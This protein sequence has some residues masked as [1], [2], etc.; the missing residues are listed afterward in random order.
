M[1][2]TLSRLPLPSN[3]VTARIMTRRYVDALLLHGEHEV[4]MA[5]LLFITGFKQRPQLIE[6]LNSS[7]TTY[8]LGRKL[9][10]LVNSVTSFSNMP[11]ILIF[12]VG[13]LIV[14]VS[15]AYSAFLIFNY[16]VF[17]KPLAGFTSLMVSIWLLG[18][19][20]IS[21]TG[22]V[23]IYLAKIFSEVKRRPNSI[24]RHIYT[25]AN[26]NNTN[27]RTSNFIKGNLNEAKPHF[28]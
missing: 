2:R 8:T 11:L 5:G 18:G 12:Y 1:I 25:N 4:F 9:G 16:F 17:S 23:G 28:R 21:F 15:G 10:L 14:A 27:E 7:K 13:S 26:L 3:V 20:V 24:I 6:K 22:V 19:L